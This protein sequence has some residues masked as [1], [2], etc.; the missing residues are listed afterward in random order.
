MFSDS[1]V[2][3]FKELVYSI[4]VEIDEGFCARMLKQSRHQMH[5]YALKSK[6]I[7]EGKCWGDRIT[8]FLHVVKNR[9]QTMV[10]L[11]W[12][13]F[14]LEICWIRR[15][16]QRPFKMLDAILSVLDEVKHGFWYHN[17]ARDVP[18]GYIERHNRRAGFSARIFA[19][20]SEAVDVDEVVVR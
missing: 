19:G 2:G 7:D 14:H 17:A 13:Y 3:M 5:R 1:I 16:F 20:A 12:I 18:R 9:R 6:W 11:I 8:G 10:E 4:D 15:A